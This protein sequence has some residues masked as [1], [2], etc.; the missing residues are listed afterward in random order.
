MVDI[1]RKYRIGAAVAAAVLAGGLA[2]TPAQAAPA[3]PAAPSGGT[4]FGGT[5]TLPAGAPTPG[6]GFVVKSAYRV[7]AG[8]QEYACTDAGT[9]ATASTPTAVLLKYGSL[10]AIYHYAGPRWRA[11]DGSTLL[12]AVATRVPK[13]G[14]IPW[15]LLTT[16]VE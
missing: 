5:F 11:L 3:A 8:V 7:V 9:W 4:V 14:T 2:G 13:D 6:D 16:T 12:G 15:L 10:R 1:K